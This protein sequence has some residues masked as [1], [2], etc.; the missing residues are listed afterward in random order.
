MAERGILRTVRQTVATITVSSL[1]PRRTGGIAVL[2][3]GFPWRLGAEEGTLL[4]PTASDPLELVCDEQRLRGNV[5]EE[6][7]DVC[8]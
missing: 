5:L 3:V 1:D 4:T 2:P 8:V 6:R 7:S